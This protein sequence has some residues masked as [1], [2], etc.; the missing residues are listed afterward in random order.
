MRKVTILVSALAALALLEVAASGQEQLSEVER[1]RAELLRVKT[2][3]A[4][5]VAQHDACKAELGA[6]YNTLGQLRADANSVQLSTEEQ[7]LK[8]S[9]DAAHPGFN[10]D[11]KT[12]AFAK[13]PTPPVVK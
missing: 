9:V 6:T 5:A 13:R 3:Y 11:P 12:G 7:Q 10:W 4:Q 2:A 1:L 8:A